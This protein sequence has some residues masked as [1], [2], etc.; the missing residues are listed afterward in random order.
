M[1]RLLDLDNPVRVYEKQTAKD[2]R[3]SILMIF[4]CMINY[5]IEALNIESSA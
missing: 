4:P 2:K 3:F 5:N 1:V